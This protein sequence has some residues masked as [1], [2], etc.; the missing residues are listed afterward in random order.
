MKKLNE[1]LIR[2]LL[3]MNFDGSKTLLE[4]YELPSDRLGSKGDFKP[5]EPIKIRNQVL[6]SFAVMTPKEQAD[7]IYEIIK[8]EIDGVG[9]DES[10]IL[11]ALGFINSKNY[12]ILLDR[13]KKIKGF[14]TQDQGFK[15]NGD[16]YQ[17]KRNFVSIIE[18]IQQ[19]EFPSGEFNYDENKEWLKRYESILSGFGDIS[20][21]MWVSFNRFKDDI[22]TSNLDGGDTIG[23]YEGPEITATQW[24]HVL[25]PLGSI[26]V[27][28]VFPPTWMALGAAALLELADAELYLKIDKDPYAAGLGAIF[29]FVPFGQLMFL[30]AVKKLGT[31]GIKKLLQKVFLKEGGYIDEELKALKELNK[32]YQK[33]SKLAKLNMAEKLTLLTL[34]GLKTAEDFLSWSAKLIDARLLDPNSLAQTGLIIGG[35]FIA[36][37]KIAAING[38]CNE[39][40]LL[41]LKQS[42]WKLL[43]GVGYAG[44]YLQPYSSP[45][46]I[47][48][49]AELLDKHNNLNTITSLLQ[50]EVDGV[51]VFNQD[52]NGTYNIQISLIQKLLIAGGFDKDL[53]KP[54]WSFNNINKTISVRNGSTIKNIKVLSYPGSKVKKEITNADKKS[55]FTFIINGLTDAVY[56]MKFEN[57]D[58]TSE[59]SKLFYLTK[60]DWIG[61]P[62]SSK[63]G[64]MKEGYYDKRTELAVI[65]YQ[66]K[67]GLTDDGLAGPATIKSILSD[68]KSQKYGL[69][70]KELNTW[71]LD[72]ERVNRVNNEFNAWMSDV[73]SKR[74]SGMVSMEKVNEAYKVHDEEKIKLEK[75]VGDAIIKALNKPL[76]QDQADLLGVE[77]V[78]GN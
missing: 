43:K 58:G 61:F 56:I 46:D 19:N 9:T 29:A 45:C 28:V 33:L 67:N 73:E 62:Q 11:Y 14:T 76:T 30:P 10:K 59:V 8:K 55:D 52:F 36:W 72:A 12:P 39:S 66:K 51:T 65:N 74:E 13:I 60:T 17:I 34:R 57:Y 18:W 26:V 23:P 70:K 25:L 7:K 1:E 75:V 31:A 71:N 69:T 22:H 44:K 37:D 32:E 27:S 42:D 5:L 53:P 68:Y 24:L 54:Q 48:K 49:A 4:Q 78:P 35:T 38:I 16:S 77:Y 2:Q 64:N 20:K 21:Y 63:I 41:G 6:N 3:L 40:P 50:K 47:N 15:G